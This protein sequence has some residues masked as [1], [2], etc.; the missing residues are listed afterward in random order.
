VAVRDIGQHYIAR[1]THLSIGHL[2]TETVERLVLVVFVLVPVPFLYIVFALCV[3]IRS[4][5]F[6]LRLA[7]TRR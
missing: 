7:S 6:W 5:R 4:R 1:G 2:L 3:F